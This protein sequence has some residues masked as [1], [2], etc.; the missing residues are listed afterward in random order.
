MASAGWI[1]HLLCLFI[2]PPETDVP[3]PTAPGVAVYSTETSPDILRQAQVICVPQGYHNLRHSRRG[4]II[5]EDGRI[6]LGDPQ[7]LYLAGGAFVEGLV[8]TGSGK[9]NGQRLYGR[10][11]L[12]GRQYPWH[13]HPD[14][15]GP[16]AFMC[17][18]LCSGPG[19]TAGS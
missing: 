2:D 3:V 8:E 7:R 19:T 15:R 12:S 9:F 11:I 5:E 16:S 14:H 10:G 1:R 17:T 18:T 6:V 4:G 13:G